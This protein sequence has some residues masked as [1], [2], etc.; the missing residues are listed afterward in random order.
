MV[1]GLAPSNNEFIDE[2][3]LLALPADSRLVASNVARTRALPW[4]WC[5]WKP[6]RF[7]ARLVWSGPVRSGP[8][9]PACIFFVCVLTSNYSLKDSLKDRRPVSA[10]GRFSL[11]SKISQFF[12]WRKKL[13]LRTGPWRCLISANRCVWEKPLD[14]EDAGN[15]ILKPSTLSS[16]V[17]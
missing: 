14:V 5:G 8:E 1:Y 13:R 9:W 12:F 16:C 3:I 15:C 6:F 2:V 4:S 11:T 7:F 17:K 10:I